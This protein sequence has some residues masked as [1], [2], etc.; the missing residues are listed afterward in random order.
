MFEINEVSGEKCS[1]SRASQKDL[2]VFSSGMSLY[3]YIG[4]IKV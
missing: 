1:L 2:T 3:Y 4:K